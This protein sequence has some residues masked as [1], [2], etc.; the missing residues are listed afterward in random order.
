MLCLSRKR[1]EVIVIG[2]EIVVT[3]LEIRGDKVRIGIDAPKNLSVHRG[4]VWCEINSGKELP[5]C[6]API[7]VPP[8]TP[9]IKIGDKLPGE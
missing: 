1:N 9:V 2:D 5:L 8:I 7:P 6:R 3:V 4:K